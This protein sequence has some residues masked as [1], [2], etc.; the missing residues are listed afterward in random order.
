MTD[1]VEAVHAAERRLAARRGQL[2]HE[3]GWSAVTSEFRVTEWRTSEKASAERWVGFSGYVD[4]E[5][6]GLGGLAW[7]VDLIRD[8]SEWRVERGLY[9][10]RNTTDHQ[11]RAADL[12]SA[13]C[14]DSRDLA[15]RLPDL[16]AEL[17][18]L[19]APAAK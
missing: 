12:P 13:R 1:L 7:I 2:M 9:L 16:L 18:D 3:P 10:N 4:G 8:G 6:A 14:R 15:S 11:E 5:Y 19:P 17:L